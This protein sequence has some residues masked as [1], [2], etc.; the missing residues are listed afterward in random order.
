MKKVRKAVI[1]VAGLGTRFLPA[2][3]AQPKEML[4]VIDKPII[5]YI[6]EEAVAAGI[7]QIIFVTSSTK[8]AIEDH[9]DR[10]FELE[11]RLRQKNKQSEIKDIL[12]ISDMAN[13]VYVRQKTPKG[14]G[15]AIFTA[16]ELVGDE[17]FAVML[18]D[19]II[20]ARVPAIKQLI[21]IY[22]KYEDIVVG[23]TR[24]P[25]KETHK[26][27]IIDPIV[28]DENSSEIRRI[29]EKPSPGKAPSNLA[30]SGRYVL[31]PEIFDILAKG[32]KG[33]GGEIQLTDAL[34]EHVRRKA[35]YACLYKGDYYDCGNK[36]EFIKATITYALKRKEFRGPLKKYLK[37]L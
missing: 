26:Y 34:A 22:N 16:R 14:L 6:V 12:R 24:V 3:K 27:G 2:T 31:T 23:V 25:K 37:Q 29:I 19:D 13:F 28:I 8:R 35:G 36:L 18:G 7:E 1:P 5:Q 10:N 20:D 17:P 21:N 4:A 33:S 9:F 32:K 15:H 30:V 11:Y